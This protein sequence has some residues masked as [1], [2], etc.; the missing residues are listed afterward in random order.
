MLF[1][2]PLTKTELTTLNEIY[3]NHTVYSVRT[4][5]HIIKLSNDGYEVKDISNICNVCRQ[6]VATCINDWE[7]ICVVA[8]FEAKRSGRKKKITNQQE[9]VLIENALNESPRSLKKV[10]AEFSE[11]YNIEL[12]LSTLKRLCKAYGLSWRRIRKSLKSKRNIE[13]FER[14][15]AQVNQ[16]VESYKKGEINLY[17]FDESGF[18]LVPSVPYAWQKKGEYIEVPSSRSENIS[19]LGFIDRNSNLE[20]FVFKG[21]VNSNIVVKC[22]DEFSKK[23]EIQDK[24]T[25]VLVD[26]SP[27][28][29]S[30]LFCAKSTEWCSKNLV[31]VP[32]ARYSPELNIIE[33]LW[34][35]IKYEWMPFSAYK[36][37]KNLE[38]N[39]TEILAHVGNKYSIQ[40][41]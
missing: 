36:S 5:A 15:K 23:T 30:N 39:L 32:I 11:K 14:S 26:N 3:K 6:T 13:E 12:S 9:K 22:F 18:S 35:K 2:N 40:F 27:L 19:V 29:T 21:S 28:H 16:L 10:I 33:I 4:R 8:I 38:E 31:V 25:I 17:Y 7:S 1:V 37:I 34:R 41:S 20:S 24:P